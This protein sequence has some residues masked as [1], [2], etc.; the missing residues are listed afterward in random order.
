MFPHVTRNHGETGQQQ[1]ALLIAANGGIRFPSTPLLDNPEVASLRT[2]PFEQGE[3]LACPTMSKLVGHPMERL[4]SNAIAGESKFRNEPASI[5]LCRQKRGERQTREERRR[6][7]RRLSPG[8][9]RTGDGNR[10]VTGARFGAV[11]CADHTFILEAL[12]GRD[13]EGPGV[14]LARGAKDV[15]GSHGAYLA[16]K[17][18]VRV[19]REDEDH[20]VA[21]K[22]RTNGG[23]GA[24]ME[25]IGNDSRREWPGHGA[26]GM[27]GVKILPC[28]ECITSK[29][30]AFFSPLGDLRSRLLG[31][32]E[33][34]STVLFPATLILTM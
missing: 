11:T 19:K 29:W 30:E 12:L 34:V 23:S 10:H 5:V 15:T 27:V 24:P 31:S 9:R 3:V 20:R 7:L 26:A 22:L 17:P 18:Q 8:V 25:D 2:I 16:G 1:T 32:R 21:E 28:F 13:E 4:Q 6:E 14:T 33:E